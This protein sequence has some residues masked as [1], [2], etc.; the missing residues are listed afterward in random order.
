MR[1]FSMKVSRAMFFTGILLLAS[2]GDLLAGKPREDSFYL[3]MMN[4][5]NAPSS[6]AMAS[7]KLVYSDKYPMRFAF[8]EDKKFYYE[9]DELGDGWG[10]YTMEDGVVKLFAHR[11]FFDMRLVV[12]GSEDSDEKRVVRFRDRSGVQTV[13]LKVRDPESATAEGRVLPPLKKF[14]KSATGI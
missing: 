7:Q 2:C 9:I 5:K 14:S 8:Y 11:P 10:H 12:S 1:G 13:E 4:S 6:V 3:A